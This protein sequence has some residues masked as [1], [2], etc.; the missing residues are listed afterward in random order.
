MPE[1]LFYSDQLFGLYVYILVRSSTLTLL[2]GVVVARLP[3]L[4]LSVS[5]FLPATVLPCSV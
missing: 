4:M 5:P 3:S 2:D 1:D